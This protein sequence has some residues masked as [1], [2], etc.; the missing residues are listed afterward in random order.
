MPVSWHLQSC[1]AEQDC[2]AHGSSSVISLYSELEVLATTCLVMPDVCK[3][4]ALSRLTVLSLHHAK[5]LSV[6][7]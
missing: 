4:S 3:V 7:F 2:A 5:C 1:E 6:G